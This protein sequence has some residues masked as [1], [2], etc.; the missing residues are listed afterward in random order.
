MT[1]PILKTSHDKA[2]WDKLPIDRKLSLSRLLGMCDEG[3]TM[4]V[5]VDD[6]LMN[7]DTDG[8]CP[9]CFTIE[10]GSE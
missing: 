5:C 4:R 2:E 6:T 7:P 9:L 8:Q 3:D 1:V 10:R